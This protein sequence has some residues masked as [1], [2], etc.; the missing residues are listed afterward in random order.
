MTTHMHTCMYM[1]YRSGEHGADVLFEALRGGGTRPSSNGPFSSG[2]LSTGSTTSG[3]SGGSSSVSGAG[4]DGADGTAGGAASGGW[5]CG[6]AVPPLSALR[7]IRLSRPMCRVAQWCKQ[8][9]QRG[10]ACIQALWYH[11]GRVIGIVR[12]RGEP[13]ASDGRH[14]RAML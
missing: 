11:A 10:C 12:R 3:S 1:P 4:V 8:L 13:V 14:D 2:G 9:E 7:R 5:V 6:G